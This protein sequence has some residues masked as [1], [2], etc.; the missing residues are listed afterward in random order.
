LKAF[1]GIKSRLH[2]PIAAEIASCLETDRYE[3][4]VRM[5]LEYYY[6]PRY[7]YTTEQYEQSAQFTLSVTG[8]E[9]AVEQVRAILD[10]HQQLIKN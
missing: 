1:N 6:D 8:L 4:A 2:T 9:D 10:R 7:N 5:L 3:P